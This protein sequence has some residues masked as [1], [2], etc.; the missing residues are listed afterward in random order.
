MN[1]AAGQALPV[2]KSAQPLRLSRLGALHHERD[3]ERAPEDEGIHAVLPRDSSGN[4][5]DNCEELKRLCC[6][7]P[8]SPS[9]KLTAELAAKSSSVRPPFVSP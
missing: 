5:I 3:I 1:D 8:H 2:E 4:V 9:A 6:R 7:P